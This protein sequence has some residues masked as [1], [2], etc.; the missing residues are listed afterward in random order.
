MPGYRLQKLIIFLATATTP[1]CLRRGDNDE[2]NGWWLVFK[3]PTTQQNGGF[4]WGDDRNLANGLSARPCLTNYLPFFSSLTL[5]SFDSSE[6][7]SKYHPCI[8]LLC[9]CIRQR[10]KE[11]STFFFT[12]ISGKKVV[13]SIKISTLEGLLQGT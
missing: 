8:T 12:M 9:S 6:K 2:D 4:E 7:I 1:K 5:E 3:A 10:Q 11:K 13:P